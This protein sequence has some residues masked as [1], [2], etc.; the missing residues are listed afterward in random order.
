MCN[1]LKLVIFDCDG[2]LVDRQQKIVAA[3]HHAF[4]AADRTA[5][6]HETLLGV[7]GL[8]PLKLMWSRP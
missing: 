6:P 2:T 1:S 3:M 4:P 5:P 7:V 8:S